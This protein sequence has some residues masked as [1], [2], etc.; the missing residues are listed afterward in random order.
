MMTRSFLIVLILLLSSVS[1]LADLNTLPDITYTKHFIIHHDRGYSETASVIGDACESWL[2]EISTRL[3]LPLSKQKRIPVFLYRNQADFKK[4]TGHDRPGRVL[5]LASTKGQIE[6][7]ASGI[8]ASPEQIAGH[9]ITHALLFQLYGDRIT[10][11]PLWLNEGTAKYIT[12]DWETID[13]MVLADAISKG[14][15][16]SLES[17]S[18]NFP[19][20][21][22]E[23]LAYAQSTSAVMFFVEKHGE[24]TLSR[25]LHSIAITGS[26]EE[27]MVKIIGQTP[28]EFEKEWRRSIEGNLITGRIIHIA[29]IIGLIAMPF[30]LLAAYLAI[31]RR[32][33]RIIDKFN[34]EEWE[35]ANRRD[36]GY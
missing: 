30:A 14:N 25:L 31:R 20:D 6:L 17:I 11:L 7:D 27:S 23:G 16:F 12:N 34:E 15:L 9:E 24:K 18:H 26:F 32:N 21:D 36:W 29:G 19:N 13:R 28:D 10:A 5:G 4:G 33:Q 35:E 22:R 1:V 2:N 3:D 8:F